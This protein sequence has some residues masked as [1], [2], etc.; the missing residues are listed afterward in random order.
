MLVTHDAKVASR[1]DRIIFLADGRIRD[2]LRL[3]LRGA[4][5][6][7]GPEREEILSAWLEQMEF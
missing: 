5:G 2:E 3:P 7:Q 6:G 4:S 1:A